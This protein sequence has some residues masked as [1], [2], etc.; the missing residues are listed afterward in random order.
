MRDYNSE[1]IVDRR[2]DL[3]KFLTLARR[4]T[5]LRNPELAEKLRVDGDIERINIADGDL[6]IAW[7]LYRA[8]IRLLNYRGLHLDLDPV[9]RDQL[10]EVFQI[11][12]NRYAREVQTAVPIQNQQND[13]NFGIKSM[14]DLA[15]NQMWVAYSPSLFL[16]SLLKNHPES[17][18]NS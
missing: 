14:L 17:Y 7:V 4:F 9:F 16:K 12:M 5:D 2:I 10:E 3:I 18:S 6:K 1:A 13:D 15:E 8:W 11:A